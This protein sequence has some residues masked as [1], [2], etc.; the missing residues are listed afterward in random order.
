M[1]QLT[2]QI[3]GKL[4]SNLP[5]NVDFI[6]SDG[7]LDYG[8]PDFI[9]K[10][11]RLELEAHFGSSLNLHGNEWLDFN[12][13][14]VKSAW[15]DFK[16]EVGPLVKLPLS[17]ANKVTQKAVAD[18]LLMLIEPRACLTEFIFEEKNTLTFEEIIRRC[19]CIPVYR[20]FANAL[21][22]FM[23]KKNLAEI[24]KEQSSHF[25]T[26]LDEK[27]IARY[28][29]ENWEKLLEPWLVMMGPEIEPELLQ[30]FFNDKDEKSR[31]AAFAKEQ[32]PLPLSKIIQMITRPATKDS[33]TDTESS[34][35]IR[36]A[37]RQAKPIRLKEEI[38]EETIAGAVKDT[39]DYEEDS[40]LAKARRANLE[41]E[42]SLATDNLDS[43]GEAKFNAL[44]SRFQKPHDDDESEGKDKTPIW[45]Q[46]VPEETDE[47]E[48]ESKNEEETEELSGSE[49]AGA[50]DDQP[51]PGDEIKETSRKNEPDTETEEDKAAVYGQLYEEDPQEHE[52][53]AENKQTD[54]LKHLEG[55]KEYFVAN[56]FGG[57][58]DVF[59]EVLEDL[60]SCTEWKDA[61]RFLT[62]DVFRRNFIDIYSEPA[63]DF[64]DMLQNYF[65]EKNSQN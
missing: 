5:D 41:E 14:T 49:Q 47:P 61:V 31:A 3:T 33:E 45:K 6:S 39:Q 46:F 23:E 8:Y 44:F 30:H 43:E 26:A 64:T 52:P 59:Q 27:L 35:Q 55:Y 51:E 53:A 24:S 10:R 2:E 58:E 29:S 60:E 56:L 21:P 62:E 19:E 40:I 12:N 16:N 36:P 22:R 9:V 42:S 28:T 63:V 1:Q 65:A 11:I 13:E 32:N 57:D 50:S 37:G 7:L 54:I 17:Y 15:Y 18:V 25:I 38:S 20:H 4:L 34:E 48:K